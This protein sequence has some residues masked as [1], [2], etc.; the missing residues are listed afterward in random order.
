MRSKFIVVN[1]G[2]IGLRGHYFETGV[3]IAREAQRRGLTTAMAAHVACD[4]KEVPPGLEFYPIFR[5]D[6]WGQKVT[7]EVPGLYGLRCC[8]RMLRETAIEDVLEGRSTMEDYLMARFEPLSEAQPLRH[9]TS[10]KA[11][12]KR[13]AKRVVPPIAIGPARWLW[14]HRHDGKQFVRSMVPP[15][16]WDR[17]RSARLRLTRARLAAASSTPHATSPDSRIELA[18]RNALFRLNAPDEADLWALFLHDLDRLLCLADVGSGD[19]VF[20]PTA[21][22]REA[23][24]IRRLIHEI[25]E[26]RSPTFHLEFRHAIAT[27]DEL[28]SETQ[29]GFLLRSTRIYQGYFDASRAY[30][31]TRLMRFYTDTEELAADYDHL[32]GADFKVLPIPF[33]A[34][35]IPSES[36]REE[37][38]GPLKVLFLGEVREEKGFQFLPG[39]VCDLFEDYVKTGKVRFIF[40]AGI[41]PDEHSRIL[42]DALEELKGYKPEHVELVGREGFI[43]PEEYYRL[44]AAADAVLCPYLTERYRARSSGVLVEAIVAGKPTVVQAGSWL[45]RQQGPGSGETF[46]DAASLA[47]AVRLLCDRYPEYKER[48]R[49]VREQWRRSHT[50]A[51]LLSCLLGHETVSRAS[52]A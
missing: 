23:F 43:D 24:A 34:D 41:H 22:G 18:L 20:L 13:V 29:D 3:S 48:A 39:L 16:V 19:H 8:L 35:L 47:E 50:P 44:L 26:D 42:C 15:F 4:A 38:Q 7:A 33:R 32:A 30:P 25:G 36:E 21:H 9:S 40:Q 49:V 46:T 31:D 10:R 17:L 28:D 12:I 6:H 27:L 2:M 51:H 52:A 14:R 45:A 11:R 5:V 1:N 37:V